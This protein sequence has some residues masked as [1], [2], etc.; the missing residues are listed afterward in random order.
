M[1]F[2]LIGLPGCGKSTLGKKFAHVLQFPFYDLDHLI[3]AGEGARITELF[4]RLGESKFR[5]IEQQ[6]LEKTRSIEK[7]VIA[8]GGG[9]P[10]FFNNMEVINLLGMSVFLDVPPKEIAQRLSENGISKRPVLKGKSREEISVTLEHL[11]HI[12]LPFYA[13]SHITIVNPEVQFNEQLLAGFQ[14]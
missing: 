12:R 7:A 6:Y 14:K 11:R 1:I 10:C 9:T 4:A 3:E 8:T 5:E 13:K 2:F